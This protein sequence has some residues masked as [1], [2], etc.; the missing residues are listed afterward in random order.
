MLKL[1]LTYIALQI[2]Q[3][4]IT[5]TLKLSQMFPSVLDYLKKNLFSP[6]RAFRPVVTV[7]L[8]INLLN[9]GFTYL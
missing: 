1:I 2:V 8:K 3:Q 9:V 4:E 7:K 5:Q 6:L